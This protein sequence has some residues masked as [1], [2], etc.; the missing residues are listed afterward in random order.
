MITNMFWAIVYT[1]VQHLSQYR[2]YIVNALIMLILL[3]IDEIISTED[4]VS[5]LGLRLIQEHEAD[6]LYVLTKQK[7]Y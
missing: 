1:L 2:D 4:Y 7:L 6:A 3:H 5:S